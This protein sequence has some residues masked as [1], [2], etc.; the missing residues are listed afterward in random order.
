LFGKKLKRALEI[1]QPE[2][3]RGGKRWTPDDEARLLTLAL[4]GQAP[5]A[6]AATLQR[7]Y[8]SVQHRLNKLERSTTGAMLNPRSESGAFPERADLGFC[9]IDL[10]CGAITRPGQQIIQ[11]LWEK[12][13]NDA[14]IA[15]RRE[16][17]IL[18][19]EVQCIIGALVREA[20]TSYDGE[21]G[22]RW[23]RVA[24]SR[25]RAVDVGVDSGVLR[26]LLGAL[27]RQRLLETFVGYP[28]VL[29]LGS[30][31]RNGRPT[32]F[33]ATSRLVE[34]CSIH[35]ITRDNIS[36]HFPPLAR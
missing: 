7:S 23:W 18:R 16:P 17:S 8:S 24:V 25:V 27:Q 4:E 32:L 34:L 10:T 31:A 2:R 20:I 1:Q 9:E 21:M 26:N 12:L 15:K 33:R 30:G 36:T 13:R 3:K 19:A 5:I 35:G 14:A 11:G 6:I 28:G 29:E 22:S